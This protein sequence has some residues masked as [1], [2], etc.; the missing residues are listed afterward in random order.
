MSGK[1]SISKLPKELECKMSF[2]LPHKSG[3]YSDIVG[4]LLDHHPSLPHYAAIFRI[5]S[6]PHRSFANAARQLK[7]LARPEFDV[8]FTPHY[9]SFTFSGQLETARQ[10]QDSK[11]WRAMLLN[12]RHA[13]I[14]YVDTTAAS[15]IPSDDQERHFQSLRT[16]KPWNLEGLDIIDSLKHVK[17]GLHLIMGPAATGKSM[18]NRA[19]SLYF[20]CLGYHVL[21]IS[22]ANSKCDAVASGLTP[23]QLYAEFPD[24]NLSKFEFLR[25]FPSSRDIG[26]SKLSRKQAANTS[27]GHKGGEVLSFQEFLIALDEREQVQGTVKQYG[28]LQAMI[29]AAEMRRLAKMMRQKIGEADVDAWA[30]LSELIDEHRQHA[31]K[32]SD[33]AAHQ[34]KKQ[35]SDEETPVDWSHYEEA[36]RACKDHIISQSRYMITTS[37]NIHSKELIKNWYADADDGTKRVGVVILIDEAPKDQEINVWAGILCPRWAH[38]VRG[39]FLFGDEK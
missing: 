29:V 25:L 12:Q 11:R 36:Y 32:A 6:D 7:H 9:N 19:L 20:W 2:P 27:V 10:L 23:A 30:C 16:C 21:S 17:G 24:W 5:V 4:R 38:A 31:I 15:R 18:L 37:G 14:P 13:D 33:V 39:V 1:K 28:V 3:Y 8:T 22:P 35:D 34:R 26:V